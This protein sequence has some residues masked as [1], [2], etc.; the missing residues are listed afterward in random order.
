MEGLRGGLL[1]EGISARAR[2]LII[3]ARKGG[4][5]SNYESSWGKWICWCSEQ[6]VYPFACDLKFILDFLAF[7]FEK[8][9]EYSSINVHRSAL[10][11]YH[12]KVDN[13]PVG[14]HPKVCSL[15]TGIFNESPPKAKYVFIWDIE[16][17]LIHVK[18]L[19][20]NEQNYN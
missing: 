13:Y 1:A 17:V 15:M 11:A 16:Q 20:S 9:Y 7:L 4:T 19:Q 3:K 18:K 12:K 14:Q 5:S 2:E 10:S 6:Q 8:N